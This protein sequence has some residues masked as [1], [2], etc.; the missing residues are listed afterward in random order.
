[1][2]RRD[3][4]AV[5]GGAA[6]TW[7]LL[8]RAHPDRVR[9]IGVLTALLKDDPEGRARDATFAERLQQLGWSEDHNLRIE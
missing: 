3:F 8:A 9:R 5:L 2:R 6:A 7:P 1:M 4:I